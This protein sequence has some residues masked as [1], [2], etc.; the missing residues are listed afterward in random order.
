L[1]RREFVKLV[2]YESVWV[3]AFAALLGR[4]IARPLESL[5]RAARRYPNE[6]IADTQ[7]RARADEIGE[8]ARAM[9]TMTADLEARRRAAVELGADVAHEFK[10]PLAI[11]AASAE[12]LETTRSLTEDKRALIS[13]SIHDAVERLRRSIDAL[14]ALLRLEYALPDEPRETVPYRAL[15][16]ELL[17][18][19]RR[20]PRYAEFTFTLTVAPDVQTVT[21]V[22]ARWLEM[23]RNLLDNALVQPSAHPAVEVSVHRVGER[24]LTTVRDHGPGVSPGNRENVFRRFYSLRPEGAPPGTGLGLS[25]VRAVASAHGGQVTLESTEGEG[26]AFTVSLPA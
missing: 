22:P 14:L 13:E 11:I 8:L 4:R 24:V 21:V 3:I 23:L 10:N 6:P 19:Y 17:D 26:A 25:I 18:T 2:L 9:H 15:L 7:I 16:D 1:F 20:D 5:A 12:L